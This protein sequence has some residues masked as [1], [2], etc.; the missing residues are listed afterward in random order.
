[1][2]NDYTGTFK[3]NE[4]QTT[5]VVNIKSGSEDNRHNSTAKKDCK[6]FLMPLEDKEGI[7]TVREE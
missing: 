2:E 7:T 6:V 1:M 5:N 4:G 3:D